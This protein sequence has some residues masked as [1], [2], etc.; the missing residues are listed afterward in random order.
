MPLLQVATGVRSSAICDK[1]VVRYRMSLWMSCDHRF[2][3]GALD[4]AYSKELR[5]LLENLALLLVWIAESAE[6]RLQRRRF[7]CHKIVERFSC[8]LHGESDHG[9]IVQKSKERNFV[10]DKIERIDE[11]IDRG[12]D[13]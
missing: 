10:W 13:R 2:I 5:H 12:D 4:A 9:G 7:P 8:P 11:V 1:I 6:H 3:D